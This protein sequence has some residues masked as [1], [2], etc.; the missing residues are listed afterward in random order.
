MLHRDLHSVGCLFIFV[1]YF[2]MATAATLAWLQISLRHCELLRCKLILGHLSIMSNLG[3]RAEAYFCMGPCVGRY[4]CTCVLIGAN[5]YEAVFRCVGML[6]L[7]SA[8]PAYIYSQ[9]VVWTTRQSESECAVLSAWFTGRIKLGLVVGR[10]RHWTG[11]DGI[12]EAMTGDVRKPK[13]P[14]LGA[15]GVVQEPVLCSHTFGW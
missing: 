14:G 13:L 1:V 9:A 8:R 6:S 2:D 3:R 12:V 11:V 5:C 15:F 7:R 4:L 10:R